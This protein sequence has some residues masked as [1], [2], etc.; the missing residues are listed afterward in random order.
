MDI[1]EFRLLDIARFGERLIVERVYGCQEDEFGGCDLPVCVVPTRPRVDLG[2]LDH[3]HAPGD[4]PS[5]PSPGVLFEP[6]RA[7]SVVGAGAGYPP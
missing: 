3:R 7:Q 4:L 2:P 1:M 5:A 6:V